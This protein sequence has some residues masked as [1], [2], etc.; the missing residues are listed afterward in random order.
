MGKKDFLKK[1]ND[2]GFQYAI[3]TKGKQAYTKP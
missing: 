2:A 1:G 3:D